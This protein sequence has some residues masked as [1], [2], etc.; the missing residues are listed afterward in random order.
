MTVVG[1][2]NEARAVRPCVDVERYLIGPLENNVYVIGIGGNRVMIVDP[3]CRPDFL[4]RSIGDRELA[5]I[6]LTHHHA[7]H[8]GAAAALREATGARVIASAV[9]KP[10]IEDPKKVGDSVMP[11]PDPCTVDATVEHGDVI[12][13]GDIA[14]K[15]LHTPGHSKGSI[16]L[17]VV[18]QL[19]PVKDGYPV[20]LSG[21]T[22]FAGSIGRT[23]FSGG[24]MDDMRKS[25]FMLAK[26]PDKTIVLPGHGEPTMIGAERQRVFA[27]YAR[28]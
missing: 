17:Y 3:A 19:A 1:Y 13:I 24:S 14:W 15:V 20:L 18:P 21:D 25:L 2:E 7:D 26:L 22:L 8:M 23:D 16:C 12:E 27:F 11:L 9:E 4:L 6:V 10:L 28:L 5:A